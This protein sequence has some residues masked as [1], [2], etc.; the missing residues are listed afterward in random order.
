MATA[1]PK[2]KPEAPRPKKKPQ[3]RV[4]KK[5]PAQASGVWTWQTPNEAWKLRVALGLVAFLAAVVTVFSGEIENRHGTWRAGFRGLRG[6]LVLGLEWHRGE[7][8]RRWVTR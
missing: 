1:Q 2:K 8:P 6:N 7:W 4:A 5:K 3:K